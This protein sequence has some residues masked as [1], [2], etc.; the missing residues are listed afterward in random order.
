MFEI[1]ELPWL[2]PLLSNSDEM[3][4][5]NKTYLVKGTPTVDQTPC[6]VDSMNVTGHCTL[7]EQCSQVY[8]QLVSLEKY[9]E[10]FCTL[11]SERQ[12][13]NSL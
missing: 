1:K 5:D 7:L 12:V 3:T 8:P 10:Y 11:D 9:R 6:R 2:T 4:L 13:L